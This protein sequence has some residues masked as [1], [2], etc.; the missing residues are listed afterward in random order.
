MEYYEIILVIILERTTSFLYFFSL[1]LSARGEADVR[2]TKKTRNHSTTYRGNEKYFSLTIMLLERLE[3]DKKVHI[4]AGLSKYPFHIQ[5]PHDIPC[6]FEQHYGHIRYTI[7]AV[8]VR[9]WRFNHECKAV[10]TIISHY[11]LNIRREQ[12]IGIHDEINQAFSCCLCCVSDGSINMHVKLPTTGFVPGQWIEAGFDL[13]DNTSTEFNKICLKLQQSCEFR[14]TRSTRHDK[15]TV[16]SVQKL[17]PF[18][19]RAVFVLRL[20]IP[21]V[22]PSELEFCGI[23]DL[24]YILRVVFHGEMYRKIVK[25][26]PIVIGTIPLLPVPSAPEAPSCSHGSTSQSTSKNGDMTAESDIVSYPSSPLTNEFLNAPPSYEESC[27]N[28]ASCIKDHTE[29]VYVYGADQPF[30]PKYPVFKFPISDPLEK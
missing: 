5:L 27:T 17:G 12:C 6:S 20:L 10:F 29:S 4:P 7:K 8:I 25:E 30:A 22:P 23:I 11:D 26:Y 18:G 15:T 16:A 1:K 14:A 9:S 3:E 24:K 13:K 19:K 2:W 28:R 21:S